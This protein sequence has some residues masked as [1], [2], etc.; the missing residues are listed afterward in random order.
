[1]AR[2]GDISQS[3]AGSFPNLPKRCFGRPQRAEKSAS[4]DDLT[5]KGKAYMPGLRKHP[6]GTHPTNPPH[7]F[8]RG[9]QGC[10]LRMPA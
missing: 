10:E 4:G 8:M 5:I 6:P 1:M 3:A 7:S 9:R 2:L